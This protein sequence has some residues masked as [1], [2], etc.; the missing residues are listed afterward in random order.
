MRFD[1]VSMSP[2]VRSACS[3]WRAN[4]SVGMVPSRARKQYSVIKH[5]NILG[6]RRTCKP[7]LRRY[8]RKRGLQSTKRREVEGGIAPL[9]HLDWFKRVGL[10]RLCKLG[11]EWRTSARGTKSAIARGPAGAARDLRKLRRG[12]PAK[13][14][15]IKLAV[16]SERDVIN[17]QIEPHPDRVGRDEIFDVAGLIELNLCVAGSRRERTKNN[18]CAAPLPANEFGNGIDLL[19]GE[20]DN[21]RPTGKPADLF[22][23]GERELRQAR[24][25]DDVRSGQ[26]PLDEGAHRLGSEHQGFLAAAIIEH[27][28]GKYVSALKV[29]RELHLIYSKECDVEIPR[30]CLHGRHPVARILRLDLFLAGNKGHY[31]GAGTLRDLVVD[32]TGK[33]SQ[34]KSDNPGYLANLRTMGVR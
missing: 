2:S 3:T 10:K 8:L 21:C 12:E 5:Q 27:A 9:Q 32:L 16:G 4:Q 13:L 34:G 6:N 11:L 30:H 31:I 1:N 19:G 18:R 28:I 24:P 15:T 7:M 14:I 33:Q 29:C 23:S 20:R 26:K 22:L 25:G 17:I